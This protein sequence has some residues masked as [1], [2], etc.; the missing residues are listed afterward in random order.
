M[1]SLKSICREFK[2]P[3]KSLTLVIVGKAASSVR[4]VDC[5]DVVS[6]V[7]S[8]DDS[9]VL[10]VFDGVTL[11]WSSWSGVDIIDYEAEP[12]IV[13]DHEERVNSLD[14]FSVDTSI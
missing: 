9:E 11:I 10:Q 3:N 2:N 12:A 4:I 7:L 1:P 5:D 8:R 13:L 14:W 6:V